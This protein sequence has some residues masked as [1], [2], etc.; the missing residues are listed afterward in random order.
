MAR[1]G[2]AR[3][4]IRAELTREIKEAARLELVAAGAAGLSLRAVARRVNL[5]PSAIYRYFAGRDALLTALIT[6]AYEDLAA[7]AEA[8]DRAAGA[9]PGHRWLAIGRAMRAW[10]WANPSQWG[11]IYGTPVPG[12][13]APPDTV[14]AGTAV[15]RLLIGLLH[16]AHDRPDAAPLP[17]PPPVDSRLRRWLTRVA[18]E[19]MAGLPAEVLAAGIFAFSSLLGA[20]STELFGQFGV[21][22]TPAEAMFDTTLRTL[23]TLLALPGAD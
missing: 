7:A 8:A 6:D 10:A 1:E 11:L 17:V 18:M 19:E 9:E 4:R 20:I 23:G 2:T 21:D 22:A 15:V 16:E 12:Y 14:V 5:V 3:Q 13:E